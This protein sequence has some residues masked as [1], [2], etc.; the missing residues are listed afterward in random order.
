MIEF[1]D[2]YYSKVM[3]QYGYSPLE[4]ETIKFS[5]GEMEQDELRTQWLCHYK[6]NEFAKRFNDD[7]KR[8]M[9][10]TGFG[11]SGPPHMGTISQ[12]MKAVR[13]QK[14]GIPVQIVLG[15]LDAVNGKSI[16]YEYTQEVVDKYKEFIIRLG[17]RPGEQYILR[18]QTEKL[19]VL[20]VAYLIGH[21]ITDQMFL[22]TEEDLHDFYS[23]R[24]KVDSTM[25]YRRKLSLNL[26]IGDFFDLLS[27]GYNNVLVYLGIDEHKYVRMA[28]KL[29]R[30]YQEKQKK[31]GKCILAS[32][33]SP[34]IKG[35]NQYPKMSKSF[36]E[37]SIH[38]DMNPNEIKERILSE[39][40]TTVEPENNVIY[41]MMS[42]VSF[43]TLDQIEKAYFACKEQSKE[44]K[45]MKMEYA[46]QL[47]YIC[48]Q[49][50]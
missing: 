45:K 16:E 47:I 2:D 35:F 36:P 41:Q 6:G 26:M 7:K 32:M 22:D 34:I 10:T 42:S 3:D 24:G 43:F 9:V 38:V 8:C 21:E 46:E 37:S 4:M 40:E 25:T 33:Y 19:D 31:F 15:D 23:Q 30:Q 48:S 20:K 49:W 18:S 28:V 13:L 50:F 14:H 29:L 12:I 1:N 27:S 44:W 5:L 17:F 39:T 11:L